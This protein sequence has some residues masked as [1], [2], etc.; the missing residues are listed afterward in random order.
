MA[1]VILEANYYCNHCGRSKNITS[2]VAGMPV[3]AGGMV[4]ND[5]MMSHYNWCVQH[6]ERNKHGTLLAHTGM[7]G[8][9]G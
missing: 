5:L 4:C 8:A 1:K 9:A 2:A 3:D 7:D 6:P